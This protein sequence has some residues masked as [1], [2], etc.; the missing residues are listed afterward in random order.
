MSEEQKNGTWYGTF[1]DGQDVEWLW[2]C[3]EPPPPPPNITYV[4]PDRFDDDFWMV[5]LIIGEYA[6]VTAFWIL[7]YPAFLT[8]A[9]GGFVYLTINRLNERF[10]KRVFL[11]L[12]VHTFY[13]G[14]STFVMLIPGLHLVTA[15]LFGYL[16]LLDYEDYKWERWDRINSGGPPVR[17]VKLVDGVEEE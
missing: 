2:F 11:R 16:A 10:G 17:I 12:I 5:W 7:G 14:V 3:E 13:L 8:M 9:I 1:L 15:P 4:I 6:T